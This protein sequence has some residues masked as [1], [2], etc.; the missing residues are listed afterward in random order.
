[1]EHSAVWIC[2]NVLHG[3]LI[4]DGGERFGKFIWRNEKKEETRE[5]SKSIFNQHFS[6]A[7]SRNPKCGKLKVLEW[8]PREWR[9]SLI[10][11]K[12]SVKS[13]S[14]RN[15]ALVNEGK[16]SGKKSNRTVGNI[17]GMGRKNSS[18]WE[19]KNSSSTVL[20]K[21]ILPFSYLTI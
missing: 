1:M 16:E 9:K 14:N 6:A 4:V 7:H 8:N 10:P 20:I 21:F 5:H 17:L 12:I 2:T 19:F 18:S 11:G 13:Q 3:L 15:T